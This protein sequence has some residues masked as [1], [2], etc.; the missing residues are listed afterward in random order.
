MKKVILILTVVMLA[1]SF[2]CADVYVKNM[3]RTQAFEIMGRS[4]PGQVEIEEHWI[5]KDKFAVINKKANFVI[6][7]DNKKLYIIIPK[8]K[9]YYQF[10]TD[11]DKEKLQ[12]LL[13][14]KVFDII[15][16]IKISDVKV[17]LDAGT[18]KI[19][20]WKCSGSELEMVFMIPALNIMP[21]MKIKMWMTNDLPFDFKDYTKGLSEFFRDMI[22]GIVSID[23]N[24]KGVMDQLESVGGFQVGSEVTIGIFGT[25]IKADTQCMEV[26]EK[27][28][29]AGIYS[30]PD[31]YTEKKISFPQK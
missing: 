2:L 27:P 15:A 8:E 22:L 6:D 26:A 23:E 4:N 5:A 16:S 10:P 20:N 19:A 11:I 25:E 1:A 12:K 13:P 17:N 18:K 9:I 21:K 24:M 28:A 14:P 31:G 29:P 3:K 30:V 7:F